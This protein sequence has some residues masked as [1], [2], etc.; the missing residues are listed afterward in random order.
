[1]VAR[2]AQPIRACE[3]LTAEPWRGEVMQA[4]EV[5]RTTRGDGPLTIPQ[6]VAPPI[7]TKVICTLGPRSLKV[8]TIRG[9]QAL[10]VSLFRIN[11]SHTPIEKVGPA[12]AFLQQHSNV[13]VCLDSEGAQI[14]TGMFKTAPTNLRKNS[15]IQIHRNPI[16]GD[17]QKLSFTPS[18]TIDLLELGDLI[19]IDFHAV[20]AEVMEIESD[21]AVLRVQKAGR[22]GNNKACNVHRH[23]ELPAITP[24]DRKAIEIARQMGVDHYALSFANRPEDVREMRELIGADATLISKI[25]SRSGIAHLDEIARLSDAILIDRGDLSRQ[26]PMQQIPARQKDIIRRVKALGRPVY[27]ATNLVESMVHSSVP[28]LAEINDIYNT[29]E[30]GVDGLVL[31]AETAVGKFPVQCVEMVVSVIAEFEHG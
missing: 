21:R 8:K 7:K 16:Y 13:P 11:L 9:L 23:V 31:A 28:T 15:L 22:V 20:V 4:I 29:L 1:M 17:A 10:G 5:N 24:K 25:E 2:L 19:T 27:V 3:A 6:V 12:I 18:A 26:V 30:D 14:R